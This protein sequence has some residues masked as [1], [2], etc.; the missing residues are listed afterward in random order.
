[1]PDQMTI[2][3]RIARQW[4]IHKEIHLDKIAK[5]FRVPDDQEEPDSPTSRGEPEPESE[6]ESKESE[7][8]ESE[9][10]ESEPESK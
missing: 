3:E 6:P 9:S 10:K 8:K 7:S 2:S 1:M 5:G 4:K